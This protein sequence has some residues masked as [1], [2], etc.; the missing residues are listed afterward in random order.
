[1][2]NAFLQNGPF[3]TTESRTSVAGPIGVKLMADR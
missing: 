1:M 3:A 2:N